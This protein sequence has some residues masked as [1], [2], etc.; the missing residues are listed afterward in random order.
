M[1]LISKF[2]P[3]KHPRVRN[4]VKHK[5]NIENTFKQA[6]LH[7]YQRFTISQATETVTQSLHI[8]RFRE[9]LNYLTEISYSEIELL[10]YKSHIMKLTI[11][12]SK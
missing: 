4:V 2:I 11:Q 10:W 6:D 7:G 9:K 1:R 5:S 12:T 3:E 8:C